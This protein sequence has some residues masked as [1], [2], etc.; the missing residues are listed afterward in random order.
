MFFI[1]VQCDYMNENYNENQTYVL[2]V[3]YGLW[4]K[5]KKPKTLSLDLLANFPKINNFESVEEIIS[6]L[7]NETFSLAVDDSSWHSD[8]E[9]HGYNSPQIIKLVFGS[10]FER[11][12]SRYP[13]LDFDKSLIQF[14]QKRNL[15]IIDNTKQIFYSEGDRTTDILR[16]ILRSPKIPRKWETDELIKQI[17]GIEPN[18][19][20]PK[21]RK[22]YSLSV[23][24]I[25]TR[26]ASQTK[27]KVAKLIMSS[28]GVFQLNLDYTYS[29]R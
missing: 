3:I 15:L 10:G 4:R 14:D 11:Y 9:K 29:K 7:S 27:G 13:S 28:R 23:R 18:F 25:N 22:H 12:A 26:V 19:V 16:I 17:S 21:D 6:V 24:E 20:S 2:Q 8:E 1:A 5:A